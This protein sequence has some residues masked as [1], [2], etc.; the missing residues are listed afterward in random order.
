MANIDP[1]PSWADIRQLETTDPNLA[2]PGGILNV[3][4]IGIA[5]RLNL[6]RD[7]ATSLNNTVSGVSS[8]QDAADSAIAT[9]QSQ[10]LDA[11]GTLS[12]L[13][14]GA[15]ISVTGDQFPDVLSID[16]SRGPVLALNESI[17]DLAQRDEFLRTNVDSTSTTLNNLQSSLGSAAYSEASEFAT[18]AQGNQISQIQTEVD[19]IDTRVDAIEAGQS[20]SALYFD[21]TAQMNSVP[22]SFVGQGAFVANG[23]GAGQYRWDGAAWQFLRADALSQKANISDVEEIREAVEDFGASGLDYYEDV[24][25]VARLIRDKSGKIRVIEAID[26]EKSV[27]YLDANG[28]T[29]NGALQALSFGGAEKLYNDLGPAY[30]AYSQLFRDISGRLRVK[31]AMGNGYSF[32]A[33]G[34]AIQAATTWMMVLPIGQSNMEGRGD[35]SLSVKVP[36]GVAKWWDSVSGSFKEMVDPVED[37]TTGSCFPSF[38]LEIWKRTGIGVIVVPCAQGSAAVTQQAATGAGQG[39]NNWSQTGALRAQAQARL[40]AA[41]SAANAAGLCWQFGGIIF[42]GGETDAQQI[43]SGATGLDQTVFKS[44]LLNLISWSKDVSGSPYS[45]FTISRTGRLRSGDTTGF[46]QVRQTQMEIVREN[47]NVFMGFTGALNFPERGMMT[48]ELHYIQSGYNEMGKNLGI[49]Q[50][51]VGLGRN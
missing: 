10:V 7:N 3:P 16:N 13:D 4:T 26:A 46:Q 51:V 28:V 25:Q 5:A 35:A 22:G 37:A 36:T 29:K 27:S 43:D 32:L 2:G 33:G 48:D 1:A 30:P 23:T 47:L 38:C 42:S 9:L 15:P 45:P 6:L 8:R 19:S 20:T 49:V 34:S 17:A 31:E 11:P 21:T 12:D 41:M 40:S 44:G 39:V 50:S 14:H 18:A 24:N